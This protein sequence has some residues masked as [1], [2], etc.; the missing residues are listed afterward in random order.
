[1]QELGLTTDLASVAEPLGW[2]AGPGQGEGVQVV[3]VVLLGRGRVYR[4]ARRY[5]VDPHTVTG[6]LHREGLG[7][8]VHPGPGRACVLGMTDCSLPL[9]HLCETSSGTLGTCP[10]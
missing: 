9:T 7:N 3:S 8:V 10:R 2:D 4:A 1:M 5:T 6:P